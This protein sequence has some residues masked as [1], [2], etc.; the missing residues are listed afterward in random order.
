MPLGPGTR[1]GPYEILS[2]I[3]V[4]GMGEVYRAR[5]TRLDR[6]V[7]LKVLPHSVA[8]S[9]I[10][11]ERFQREARAASTLNHP[12]ICTRYDVG[13]GVAP[14]REHVSFLVMELLE[15]ET[16]QERLT[17]GALE[18]AQLIDV[19]VALADALEAAHS[20]GIIHRDIKPSNI[21]LTA[22]G[23][24][25]LD[26]GLAKAAPVPSLAVS[27]QATIS[28]RPGGHVR[29]GT[30]SSKAPW[31]PA[32]CKAARPTRESIAPSSKPCRTSRST[33]KSC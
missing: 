22:R 26:F 27:G 30:V 3:G 10:A 19:G 9:P 23:P 11:L 28:R 25:L 8:D 13:E 17:R 6:D 2:A 7:A 29:Q 4:G 14:D 31:P 5:D 16:L 24:K 32:R 12:N 20:R 1:L 15:G 18:I 33:S 21:F